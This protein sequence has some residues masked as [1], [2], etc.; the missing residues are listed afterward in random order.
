MNAQEQVTAR[1]REAGFTILEVAVVSALLVGVVSLT[2]GA[3]SA[4]TSYN[5][6]GKSKLQDRRGPRATLALLRAEFSQSTLERDPRTNVPR[7]TVTVDGAGNSVV[8][9][10]VLLGARLASDEVEATWSGTRQVSLDAKTGRLILRR[11]DGSQSIIGTGFASFVVGVTLDGRIRVACNIVPRGKKHGE[12]NR[13]R[14]LSIR[15]LL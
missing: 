15:P 6:Y 5:E 13:E 10:Q 7:F 2:F 3:I 12:K 4:V 9:Y 14:K 1:R 8:D 11:D